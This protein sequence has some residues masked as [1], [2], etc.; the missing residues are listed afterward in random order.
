LIVFDPTAMELYPED[1]GDN[2][3]PP[4]DVVLADEDVAELDLRISV[5]VFSGSATS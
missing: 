3:R 5:V 4:Q 1:D 2:L